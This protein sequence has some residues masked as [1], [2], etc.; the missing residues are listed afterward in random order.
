MA[1]AFGEKLKQRYLCPAIAD[2]WP[3]HQ[4]LYN[5]PGIQYFWP[6]VFGLLL[7][8]STEQVIKRFHY[9]SINLVQIAPDCWGFLNI[10]LVINQKYGV[11]YQVNRLQARSR[12]IDGPL[13]CLLLVFKRKNHHVIYG[14]LIVALFKALRHHRYRSGTGATSSTRNQ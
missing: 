12:V 10:P 2:N 8:A 1:P 14:S 13:L 5:I 3:A 6:D 11:G 9:L 7:F 4:C